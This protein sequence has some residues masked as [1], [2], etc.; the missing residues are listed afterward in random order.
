[1]KVALV[2]AHTSY[3]PGA[4]ARWHG[5]SEYPLSVLVNEA[6]A[7]RVHERGHEVVIV[8][9]S[10]VEPYAASL[11]EK[12]RR[13]NG[14]EVEL[15]VETHFNAW[16]PAARSPGP[17]VMYW[18]AS[19]PGLL[20]AELV[21]AELARALARWRVRRPLIALPDEDFGGKYLVRETRAPALIVELLN[22]ASRPSCDYLAGGDAAAE[23]GGGLGHA[24]SCYLERRCV[25]ES[26]VDH[27]AVPA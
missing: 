15:V 4:E 24:L 10:D 14:L 7:V 23:L 9:G 26:A 6:A 1:M 2:N 16:R 12:V 27:V 20:A 25:E 5:L 3:A 18:G 21:Q 19:A 22:F 11:I 8:D 13:V 17:F